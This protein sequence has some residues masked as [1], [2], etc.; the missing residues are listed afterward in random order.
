MIWIKGNSHFQDFPVVAK[1][2]LFGFVHQN[3]IFSAI[4]IDMHQY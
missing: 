3:Q 4:C 2:S 1:P